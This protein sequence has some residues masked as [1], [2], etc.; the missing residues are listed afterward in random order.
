MPTTPPLPSIPKRW[1]WHYR[2]LLQVRENLLHHRDEH[3]S[4]V[5]T[6]LERGGEDEV[7]RA[8]EEC[9][10]DTLLAEIRVEDAE[11]GEVEAALDRIRKGTYGICELTGRPISAARLRAL[12]WTRLSRRAAAQLTTRLQ[13]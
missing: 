2:A 5:R 1:A 6:T 4:A 11:L 3:T 7:D 10:Q 8:N 13:R 9:E 12:P